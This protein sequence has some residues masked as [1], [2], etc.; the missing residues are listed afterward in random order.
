MNHWGSHFAYFQAASLLQ[1]HFRLHPTTSR[2][3][4]LRRCR[5]QPLTYHSPA[6][7]SLS[8]VVLLFLYCTLHLVLLGHS[9]NRFCL[10]C[11]H[12]HHVIRA[13]LGP[14]GRSVR[15]ETSP[16]SLGSLL[17]KWSHH[18]NRRAHTRCRRRSFQPSTSHSELLPPP[19]PFRQMLPPLPPKVCRFRDREGRLCR[20]NEID[21]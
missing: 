5:D 1:D 8:I 16:Q 3:T 14:Q 6:P 20:G 2:V 19:Y 17:Q 4:S 7:P 11:S 15:R 10:R 9:F 21:K 13:R 18:L 12:A